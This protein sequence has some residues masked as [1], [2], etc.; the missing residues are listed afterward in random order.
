M[1][2]RESR[3]AVPT[4]RVAVAGLGVVL[5]VWFLISALPDAETPADRILFVT[6][7]G[8]TVLVT[9]AIGGMRSRVVVAP[10]TLRLE[11]SLG[12][13]TVWRR[14]VHAGDVARADATGL[15][16]LS[17]GGWGLRFLGPRRWALF[18]RSGPAVGVA[19]FD[20]REYVV[21]TDRPAD[22]L[23]AVAQL[24]QGPGR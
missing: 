20:G 9:V 3:G 6:I 11:F 8:A 19:L 17:A 10:E 2:F 4:L 14:V 21:G 22:L 12:G 7:A 13:V 23:D 5:A 18:V 16:A 15:S 24:R 1:L